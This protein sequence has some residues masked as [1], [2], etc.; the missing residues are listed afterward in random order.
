MVQDRDLMALL[1]ALRHNMDH[2]GYDPQLTRVLFDRLEELGDPRLPVIQELAALECPGVGEDD[3]P[4]GSLELL[5]GDWWYFELEHDA[6]HE[7]DDWPED[8]SLTLLIRPYSPL[9]ERIMEQ[10][11]T[12]WQTQGVTVWPLAWGKNGDVDD[13]G[14]FLVEWVETGDDSDLDDKF[15]S[16]VWELIHAYLTLMP[17]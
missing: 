17:G 3:W 15:R 7:E 14:V 8:S 9:A 5:L 4:D 12:L 16:L 6:G 11:A 10:K 13:R 1:E 2:S